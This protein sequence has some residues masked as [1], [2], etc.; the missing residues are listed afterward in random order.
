MGLRGYAEYLEDTAGENEKRFL[1]KISALAQKSSNV[2]RNIETISRIY[3]MQPGVVNVDLSDILKKEI[4]AKP[5]MN[6]A[7]EGCNRNVLANDMLGVVF[8]NIFS[9]SLKFGGSGVLIEVAARDAGERML[10]ISVTDNGPG[11]PDSDEIT[12]F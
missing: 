10:E 9:N 2:I 8:D 1:K 11:I 5:K 3:K 12:G 4:A 7:L 6:I